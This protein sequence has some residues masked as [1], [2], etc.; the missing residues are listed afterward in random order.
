M[1][2]SKVG[3]SD[4]SHWIECLGVGPGEWVPAE[5]WR[6]DYQVRSS[7]DCSCMVCDGA[8]VVPC[9]I[10]DYGIFSD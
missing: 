7:F 4:P 8:V 2:Y 3:C 6:I 9:C 10:R 1:I 5:G